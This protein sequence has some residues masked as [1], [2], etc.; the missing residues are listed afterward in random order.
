MGNAV[1]ICAAKFGT[2]YLREGD[3]F[4]AVALHNAPPAY[5][6][7]RA[8]VVHPPPDSPFGRAA[9]TKQAVQV[10]DLTRTQGYVAGDPFVVSAVE[11]GGYR[12]GEEL[13]QM[14]VGPKR[15]L[16]GR[17]ADHLEDLRRRGLLLQRFAQRS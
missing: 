12:T 11:R 4:R 6:E 13:V 17:A 10:A 16:A 8:A 3:G 7:A 15:V 1:R 2:L 5:A 14:L 9:K